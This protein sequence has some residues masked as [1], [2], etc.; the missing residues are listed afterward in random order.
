ML[1]RDGPREVHIAELK[2]PG[3]RDRELVVRASLA[4]T[5]RA[6]HPSRHTEARQR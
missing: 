5:A 2:P 3:S 6:D 1:P 4:V